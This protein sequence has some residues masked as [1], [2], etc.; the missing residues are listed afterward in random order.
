M[1]KANEMDIPTS[2]ET[3]KE[4]GRYEDLIKEMKTFENRLAFFN[5]K[6]DKALKNPNDQS[7]KE[8]QEWTENLPFSH[9]CPRP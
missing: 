9:Q 8:L 6:L 5:Q 4:K 2:T 3:K 1:K 7:L